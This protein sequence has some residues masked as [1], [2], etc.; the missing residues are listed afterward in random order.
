MPHAT[1]PEYKHIKVTQLAPTFGA[2][3][4]GVDFS[5][6]VPPD[7]FKEILS[8]IAK[9]SLCSLRRHEDSSSSVLSKYTQCPL[10]PHLSTVF[11]SFVTPASTMS[12][13]SPSLDFLAS[14]TTSSP[15][16]RL[17]VRT[18]SPLTNYSMFRIRKTTAA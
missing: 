12:V 15:T 3:V 17:D 11:L 13:M 6:P 9:V 4:S 1:E 2:E 18:A 10:T 5:K 14:S 8:A 7:V 16:S